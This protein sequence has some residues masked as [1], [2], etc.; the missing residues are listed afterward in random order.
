[1]SETKSRGM[2]RRRGLI[3]L[4]GGAAAVAAGGLVGSRW[5]RSPAQVA[6]DTTA[7][8]R[9]VLTAPVERRVL[10]DTVVLR[11][12]IS[13]ATSYEVTPSA[14]A[15]QRAVVTAVMVKV[16]DEVAA[17]RVLLEVA[18]RPLVALPGAVP[19]YRDLVPDSEGRDVRQLQDALRAIGH[20]PGRRNGIYGPGTERAVQA[21]Y[22]RIGYEAPIA[23]NAPMLPLNEVVFLPSFPARVERMTARVG[24]DVEKPL[25]TLSS[26]ALVATTRLTPAQ[27][28]LLRVGMPAEITSELLGVTIDGVVETIEDLTPDAE[29]ASTHEMTVRP[30]EPIDSKLAGANVRLTVAAASTEGEVLVVPLTAVFS[31]TDGQAAVLRILPGGGEENIPVTLGVTGDG[32]VAVTPSGTLAAGDLVVVGA[33]NP[34]DGER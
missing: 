3:W 34:Q 13:A 1:M 32:Y 25:I 9:T 15:G 30:L 23:G 10:R 18:G 33:D 29:G 20:D 4:A 24:V 6:A 26:G 5:V 17:G 2:S 22:H 31:R 16:S 21:F 12:I 8:P 7:P 28:A 14:P 19:A 11:A 27:Q